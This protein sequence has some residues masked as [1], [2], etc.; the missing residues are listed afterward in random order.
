MQHTTL[1]QTR[2][3]TRARKTGSDDTDDEPEHKYRQRKKSKRIDSDDE[4]R[5]MPR[6][7]ESLSCVRSPVLDDVHHCDQDIAGEAPDR[8]HTGGDD[9]LQS[10]TNDERDEPS[11]LEGDDKLQQIN[12]PPVREAVNHVDLT[13][14]PEQSRRYSGAVTACPL[15]L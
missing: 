6:E 11:H 10:A 4:Y 1:T 13:T 7:R 8:M 3:S 15:R 9:A 5:P 14:T 12:C 2:A